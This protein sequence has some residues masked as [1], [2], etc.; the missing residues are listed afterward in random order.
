MG[1]I[2][3]ILK[4]ILLLAVLAV[5][6]FSVTIGIMFISS[7]INQDNSLKVFGYSFYKFNENSEKVLT[8]IQNSDFTSIEVTTNHVNLHIQ[9]TQETAACMNIYNK[10]WGIVKTE[11]D[12]KYGVN[13]IIENN[14]L[15]ITVSEPEGIY[16]NTTSSNLT[17]K[18]PK[19]FSTK[20]LKVNGVNSNIFI[21]NSDNNYLNVSKI[22]LNV[23]NAKVSILK[24]KNDLS[25]VSL[26]SNNNITN[27]TQNISG[28]LTANT[29]ISTIN[30]NQAN[31]VN[32]TATNAKVDGNQATNISIKS[33]SGVLNID[34]VNSVYL[35][36]NI[37]TTI[38][39]LTGNYTDE[40]RTSVKLSI[41]NATGSI[42]TKSTSGET[43]IDNAT[44][45][46]N[47]QSTIGNISVKNITSSLTIKTTSGIC[48]VSYAN[49]ANQNATFNF[50][51]KNGSLTASNIQ[52]QT[53]I[54]VE[55]DGLC[56]VTAQFAKLIGNNIIRGQK[57]KINVTAVVEPCLL[58][59]QSTGEKDINYAGVVKTE[60]IES[61]SISGAS[62]SSA[63][64]QLSATSGKITLKEQN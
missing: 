21:G 39:N 16:L 12:A 23:K 41:S 11:K 52:C 55:T 63:T 30:F 42:Q 40:N 61:Q 36:G 25:E 60:N 31:T 32:V 54:Q 45:D 37:K 17:I 13:Y 1:F 64:L 27:I 35:N 3:T 2:R 43:H 29:K 48:Q 7:S 51:A 59:V 57:G 15:K 6:V 34:N 10:M 33:E 14:V 5:A 56:S 26:N 44:Q 53:N 24:I 18:L 38:A 8:E 9:G 58:T 19:N 62:Q 49:N 47:I 28:T 4:Y 22:A 50:T 46:I 20:E